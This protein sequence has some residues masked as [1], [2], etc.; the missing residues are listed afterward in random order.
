MAQ[1]AEYRQRY[2]VAGKS[3]P[4]DELWYR[5]D[6]V[7]WSVDLKHYESC[8]IGGRITR[9]KLESNLRIIS[10]SSDGAFLLTQHK[11][12]FDVHLSGDQA[13]EEEEKDLPRPFFLRKS[14][15]PSVGSEKQINKKCNHRDF[16]VTLFSTS[17]VQ[18]SEVPSFGTFSGTLSGKRAEVG[19][20]GE[21]SDCSVEN[22]KFRG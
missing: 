12:S 15:C 9:Q 22:G 17:H 8:N 1:D 10:D 13:E 14:F 4:T 11:L 20:V 7:P 18:G 19:K 2:V 3:D 6:D 16:R 21:N 5:L